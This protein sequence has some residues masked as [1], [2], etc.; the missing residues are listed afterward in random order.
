MVGAELAVHLEDHTW[1]FYVITQINPKLSGVFFT[2]IFTYQW[3]YIS[4]AGAVFY[5]LEG[6]NLEKFILYYLINDKCFIILII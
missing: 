3:S 5:T 1:T 4:M 6:S 2:K